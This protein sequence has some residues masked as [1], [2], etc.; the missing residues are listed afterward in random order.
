MFEFCD[1]LPSK[2]SC[3]VVRKQL[4]RSASSVAANYRAACR[5]VSKTAFV[6][7][8]AVVEEE[9]DE[10]LFWLEVLE[11]MD[12]G[13]PSKGQKLKSEA[14]QLVAIT[15]ASKKTSRQQGKQ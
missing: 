1:E 2:P 9:A 11:E 4:L 8:L 5:A 10:S 14:D 7:K 15:G 13:H 3:W 12:V 6:A